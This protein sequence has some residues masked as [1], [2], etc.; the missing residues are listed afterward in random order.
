V[1]GIGVPTSPDTG[2]PP[3]SAPR[4][5]RLWLLLPL[6]VFLALV[7]LF[8]FRLGAGDPSRVPS[9]L[10]NKPVPDFSLPPLEEGQDSGLADEDLAEGVHVVNVWAS[11]CG[12][13]RL[14]H[15]ILMGL[16]KD[17]RIHLVGINY[18]DIPENAARFMGALGNPFERI[19]AD[20]SGKTGIDWGVYGVPETFVVKDGIIVHKFIGPLDEAG[21]KSDLMPAIEKALAR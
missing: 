16:A 10:L 11:W 2:S 14:E 13:C 8:Y 18:K 5:G 1:T 15:P 7:G 20:R 6:I 4:R 21:Q 9:A 17:R 12:P 3:E 19:G